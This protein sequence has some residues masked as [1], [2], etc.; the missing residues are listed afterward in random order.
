MEPTNLLLVCMIA[1]T[2]VMSVLGFLAVV[3]TWITRLFPVREVPAQSPGVDTA[4]VAAIQSVVATQF[5]AVVT[6]IEESK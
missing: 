1:F 5:G 2:L 4:V 3:M 6:R